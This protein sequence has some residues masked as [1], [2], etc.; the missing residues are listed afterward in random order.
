VEKNNELHHCIVNLID[1]FI[2]I[3]IIISTVDIVQRSIYEKVIKIS[4]YILVLLTIFIFLIA[5]I[6]INI[7]VKKKK[8]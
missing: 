8:G 7:A 1:T 2:N 3:V 5:D 6:S 4:N